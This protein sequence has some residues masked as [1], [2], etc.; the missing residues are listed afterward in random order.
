MDHQITSLP[1]AV[2]VTLR[3]RL[4]FAENGGV[5]TLLDSLAALPAGRPVVFDLAGVEFI[6]SA[7]LGLLLH[8]RAT[9]AARAA[10]L[11]L[12]NATGQVGRMLDLARI[13]D[14]F[15]GA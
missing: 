2:R 12:C 3:G 13:G 7:G 6:D 14:L 8:A 4:T 9:L 15:A 1:D 10:P 11:S 5:R